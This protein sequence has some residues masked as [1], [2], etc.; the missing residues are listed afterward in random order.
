[1]ARN[2]KGY[3]E[4]IGIIMDENK[5]FVKSIY[6]DA[7]YVFYPKSVI[8]PHAIHT[9]ESFLFIGISTYCEDDA[10][11]NAEQEIK[12]RMLKKLEA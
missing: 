7:Y 10:W 1:M 8:Y 2:Q 6:P 11:F 5:Q 12:Y 3:V 9:R 4:E